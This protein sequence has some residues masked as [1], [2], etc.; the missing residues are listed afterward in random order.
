MTIRRL[1][2][3]Q[4]ENI[5]ARQYF[6][7]AQSVHNYNCPIWAREEHKGSFG[8]EKYQIDHIT[9]LWE[10]GTDDESNLQALCLSCHRVKTDRNAKKRAKYKS[11]AK[12]NSDTKNAKKLE[13]PYFEI[14]IKEESEIEED[15]DTEIEEDSDTEME[16]TN[17]TSNI[18]PLINSPVTT[19]TTS[20]NLPL[21]NSPVTTNTTSNRIP[22][23]NSPATTINIIPT[24]STITFPSRPRSNRPRNIRSRPTKL[25]SIRPPN[26][27]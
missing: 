5:A 26:K 21:I 17:T 19:N 15:S 16:D 27:P 7:C 25:S 18:I 4:K 12:K 24:R 11:D 6:K 14:E 23:I 13:K 20:N 22:L 9:E 8:P 3:I 2:R 1:T 10:G